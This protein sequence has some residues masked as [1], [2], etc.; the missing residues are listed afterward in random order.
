MGNVYIFIVFPFAGFT[1][2]CMSYISQDYPHPIYY[3]IV[4]YKCAALTCPLGG[5]NK[6]LFTLSTLLPRLKVS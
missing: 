5:A 1:Y 6:H 3:F 4:I 2:L